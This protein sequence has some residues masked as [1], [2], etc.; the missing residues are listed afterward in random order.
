MA[1]RLSNISVFLVLALTLLALGYMLYQFTARKN[2]LPVL[3][4]PG[5]MAG[6]FSFTNQDGQVV[7]RQMVDG[8]TTVVEY[9][10]TTCPGICKI[11]N[12]N[13]Q[14]I[15]DTF[16]N[17]SNLVILSHTVNPETDSVPVMAAYAK[18]FGAEAPSW[19]LLTGDKTALYK[20]ARE[21]YLLAVED[22]AKNKDFIHTE[23]VALVDGKR[24]VR[25]FYDATQKESIDKLAADIRKLLND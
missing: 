18:T 19:Q 11:M 10:F 13:L 12:R 25:G 16:K 15:H 22:S 23:Y 1:T 9:F 24:R 2:S 7:T 14:T 8:K 4:E 21:D 6:D 5:H 17:D 20:A 3:G